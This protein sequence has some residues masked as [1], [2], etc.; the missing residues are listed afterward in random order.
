[1]LWYQLLRPT[2]YLWI[3]DPSK[4]QIDFGVPVIAAA[5]ST[6]AFSVLPIRPP[7]FG[8]SGLMSIMIGLLQI[9]PGFYLSALAAV[10]TFNRPAMDELMPRPTPTLAVLRRGQWVPVELTRRRMLSMLF[11]YLTFLCF[12]LY[13]TVVVVQVAAQSVAQWVPSQHHH[14]TVGVFLFVFFG[15]MA[16]LACITLF[17]LYQL[18]DRM[19]HVD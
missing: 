12:A 19:H 1:M 8:G 18:A 16:Q 15:G 2:Q 5:L 17:G 7:V 11:G 6:L 10:A 4:W 13:L 3:K 14:L 9:L